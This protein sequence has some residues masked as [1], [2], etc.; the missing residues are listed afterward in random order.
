[1]SLRFLKVQTF[2]VAS[3]LSIAMLLF[4]ARQHES[5]SGPQFRRVVDLTEATP[6]QQTKLVA[7]S[8]FGGAWTLDSLPPARLV[9]PLAVIRAQHKNFA[10]SES[11]VTMDDVATYE[12][13]H[14]AVPQGAIVLLK[15]VNFYPTLNSDALHFL[16]EARNIVAIGGAADAFVSPEDNPYLARNGIYE[17]QDVANLSLV[18]DSGVVAIAAPQKIGAASEGPVR[19]IGLLK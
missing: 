17:L 15:S 10:N 5:L 19:L 6:S 4:A 7:P 14:G 13:L 8:Q 3:T 18:P 12:R 2:V 11:L 16:V 9:G 1:M